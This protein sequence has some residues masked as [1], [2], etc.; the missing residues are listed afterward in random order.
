M[1]SAD[2]GSVLAIHHVTGD[3]LG[4]ADGS[5]LDEAFQRREAATACDHLKF[6]VVAGAH[7]QIL[8]EAVRGD[9]GGEFLDAGQ[10]AGLA[11]VGGGRDQFVQRDHFNGRHGRL[12]FSWGLLGE[13]LTGD[14]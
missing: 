7:L 4:L 8:Q 2:L 6:A 9:A 10:C 1:F 13:K 11:H 14:P 3:V 5:R 12:L